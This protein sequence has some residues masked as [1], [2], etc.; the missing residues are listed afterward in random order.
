MM[1]TYC[2]VIRVEDLGTEDLRPYTELN[3]NQLRHYFEPAE[4]G[5]FIAETA[6]VVR[7]ALDAGYH[8]LSL[9]I[10]EKYVDTEAKDILQKFSRAA[11]EEGSRIP[12]YVGALDTLS[13][14]TGYHL[15]RGII[16]A[17]RRR[18]MQSVEEICENAHTVAVLEHV[19]NPAN[20][21][22]IFRSAA[23]MGIDAVLVSA[24]CADPLQRR[25]IR[26]SVG[27]VFQIPWTRIE[28]KR[29]PDE[30][31]PWLQ[32]QGFMVVSMAL[33]DDTISISDPCL[34]EYNRL[35]V[36]LGNEGFGLNDRTIS[37]SDY[38]VK[39][40]MRKGVDSLNVAAASAVAFWEM[41]KGCAD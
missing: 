11:E 25:A 4:E 6:N 37:M 32:K 5:I 2:P 9:L 39:I 8:P 34:R 28:E 18:K 41:A 26:V 29:W 33:R 22:A 31:L 16:A 17:F 10:E 38:T 7:R 14:M 19:E 24:G 3:E 30:V 27:T 23:A 40:P 15:T 35:A 20:I 21:G 12:V 13:K 1:N 36:C